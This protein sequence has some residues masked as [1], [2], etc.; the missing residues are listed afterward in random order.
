MTCLPVLRIILLGLLNWQATVTVSSIGGLRSSDISSGLV[1]LPTFKFLQ[2]LTRWNLLTADR[3]AGDGS[4]F[5]GSTGTVLF[6]RSGLHCPHV[7][8]VETNSRRQDR[9]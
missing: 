8:L 6:R 9:L 4:R 2:H 5:P 7:D 3:S 1:D